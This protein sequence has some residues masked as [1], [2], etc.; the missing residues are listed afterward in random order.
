MNLA[1]TKWSLKWSLLL[2]MFFA[3]ISVAEAPNYFLLTYSAGASWNEAIS[4]Q[5]QPGLKTHHQ[6]VKDLFIN[7]LVVMG[8]P[9]TDINEDYL[10]VLLLRTGSIEEA[11][12]IANQDP[13][14]QTR[15][16]RVSV[17]PWS[18]TMSSMRFSPRRARAPV[19]APDKTF[20]I[21]R[22]DPESRLN[23]AD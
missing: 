21:K 11:K 20:T 1:S 14:V 13:G 2:L 12:T 3:Q 5:N 23:I 19:D 16:I 4:Y 8:G 18:V 7:D 22:V 6:Y 17:I 10:G 9:V 15:L